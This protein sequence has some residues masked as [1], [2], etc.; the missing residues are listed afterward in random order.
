MAKEKVQWEYDASPDM[1]GNESES[2]IAEDEAFFDRV[3]A[4]AIVRL[5]K[6]DDDAEFESAVAERMRKLEMEAIYPSLAEEAIEE[7]TSQ[8]QGDER[9]YNNSPELYLD[10]GEA[11]GK[12]LLEG[13]DPDDIDAEMHRQAREFDAGLDD[14][15]SPPSP[16][17]DYNF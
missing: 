11:A 15:D 16:E 6:K 5:S 9:F 8:P 12:T 14:D 17:D 7:R 13:T 3:D 4:E 10:E 1:V 2:V